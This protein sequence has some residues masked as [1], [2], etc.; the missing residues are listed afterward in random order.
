MSIATPNPAATTTVTRDIGRLQEAVP[1]AI[2]SAEPSGLVIAPDRLVEVGSFLRDDPALLYDYLSMVT[3]VDYPD[4]FEVVYYLYS[5]VRHAG[6]IVL[7][8]QADKADPLVPSLVPVWAGADL[9]EREVYDMMGIRFSGHPNLKRL[10]MWDGFA[11][12]PLRKDYREPFFE[13]PAKPFASRWPEGNYVRAEERV[14]YHDNVQYPAGFDPQSYTP[15]P[16]VPAVPSSAIEGLK[17]QPLVVNLG[18]Q[19]PST[20]GVFRMRAVLDG[21]RVLALEPIIGYMHRNHEKIG[22]RTPYMGI[23]PY[24]DRLDYITSMT[25]NLAYVLTVEKLLGI[26][27]PERAE[28]IRV[29]MSELTRLVNHFVLI[30]FLFNDLGTFFTP[31]LYGLEER[32]LILDL[33]EMASGSRMMC[34]YM[35]FGGVAH[36]LPDGFIERAREL[37][38]DRLPKILDQ[39]EAYLN[40]NEIFQMRGIGVGVLPPAAAINY[41]VTGPMLRASGV[42]YDIRRAEP[43]SIYDRFDFDI[44]VGANGDVYDRY[45][46]RLAEMRQSGRILE[47]ALAQIPPGEIQAGKKA[48]LVRPPKGEAYARI[49]GP[50]GE[51]G[52]YVVSDGSPTPYRYHIRPPSLVNLTPLSEM[53]KGHKV[54]DTVVIFGSVDITLGEVDR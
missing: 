53:C 4:R 50:K 12:F 28:Y 15:P 48:W 29:I 7:K 24:T 2:V 10:L 16:D 31:A 40:S 5:M 45:V 54:A 17:T 35:R 27:P 39:F 19:H 3:S 42:K 37:A 47:Q 44:P 14:P 25:N 52:F 18:P 21:E 6:P 26:K 34:N 20:H 11:G 49:E 1:G 51:L 23:I 9:Q 8:V 43:Y 41:S 30:G 33:F 36:D 46:V 38:Q 13:E 32:E 22:E